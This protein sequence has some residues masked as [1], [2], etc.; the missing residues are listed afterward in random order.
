MR[1]D[2]VT[3]PMARRLRQA[4]LLWEPQLG[5]WCAVLASASLGEALAG[6]WLVAAVANHAGMLVATARALMRLRP[7]PKSCSRCSWSRPAWGLRRRE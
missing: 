6:L 3:P 7:W 1:E 5:D 2:V 4:G